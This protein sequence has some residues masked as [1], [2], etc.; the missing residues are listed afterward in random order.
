MSYGAWMT[1]EGTRWLRRKRHWLISAAR[2]DATTAARWRASG[3]GDH[4]GG[5]ARRAAD[6]PP[7]AVPVRGS[8][9]RHGSRPR[10]GHPGVVRGRPRRGHRRDRCAAC[11]AASRRRCV[12]WWGAPGGRWTGPGPSPPTVRPLPGDRL[13]PGPAAGPRPVSPRARAAGGA[14]PVVRCGPGRPLPAAGGRG[15]GGPGQVV[16]RV[17]GEVLE[18]VV[19]EVRGPEEVPRQRP[20]TRRGDRGRRLGRGEQGGGVDGEAASRGGSVVRGAD[21]RPLRAGRTRRSQRTL[22]LV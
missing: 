19:P 5:S 15:G 12:M 21:G 22:S 17:L 20:R 2:R 6:G 16:G 9:G 14:A 11:A 3:H 1:C 10:A 18:G 7:G 13:R 4:D 8:A